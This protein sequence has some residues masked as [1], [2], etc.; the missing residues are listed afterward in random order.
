[1]EVLEQAQSLHGVEARGTGGTSFSRSRLLEAAQAQV[2][3]Q[4][5]E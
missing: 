3:S 1:M 2:E 5:G 4:K